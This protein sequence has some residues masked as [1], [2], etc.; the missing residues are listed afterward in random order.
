[1]SRVEVL[2]AAELDAKS[3]YLDELVR[4]IDL[5]LPRDSLFLQDQYDWWKRL[6]EARMMAESLEETNETR[7]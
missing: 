7:S 2:R 4:T 3:E 5:M 6:E 1:M